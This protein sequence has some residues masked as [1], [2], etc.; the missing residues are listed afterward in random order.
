MYLCGRARVLVP[1]EV[2]TVNDRHHPIQLETL[3][4]ELPYL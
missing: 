3:W 2:D 4:L 1:P